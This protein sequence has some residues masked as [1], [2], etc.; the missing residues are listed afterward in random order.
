MHVRGY[1]RKNGT[2][3]PDYEKKGAKKPPRQGSLFGGGGFDAMLFAKPKAYHPKADDHGQRVPIYEPN[4]PAMA[5]FRDP[6]RVV[7]ITPGAKLPVAS[8]N[9]VAFMPW[10]PPANPEDWTHV[11]G[12]AHLP[13]EPEPEPLKPGQQFSTGLV[14]M[15]PDGRVWL[16]APTNRFGGYRATFP[17]GR[18]EADGSSTFQ[19]NAIKEAW[20]ETGI[21]ARVVGYLG[22]VDR[23]TTRTRYY[24]AVRESGTPTEMGWESQ[25]VHLVPVKKLRSFLDSPID[26]KVVDLL[27][28]ALSGS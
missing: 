24:L 20:E 11:S 23:K 1:V 10:K 21:K 2:F 19:S 4:K 25:A 3:V 22:D 13:D 18:V 27:E 28:S 16:T 5:G 17:K 6:G 12:Q 8:L 26:H 14:I 15:E 7:T 9:G